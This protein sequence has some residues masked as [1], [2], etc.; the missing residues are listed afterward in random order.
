MKPD[1][2][3][4]LARYNQWANER[5][6]AACGKLHDNELF[7]QRPSFFGSIHATLNHI[8]V[9]DRIWMGR[10]TGHP[11]AVTG[12]DEILYG[13]FIGL[14]VARVAEDAQIVTFCDALDEPTVN[15]TLRYKNMAGEAQ[16]MPIRWVLTHMFNHQTHHRGQTHGLLSQTDVPPP[17]LDLVYYLRE[18]PPAA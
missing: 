2:F 14:N 4:V 17:S 3:R 9:A 13:D 15:T 16:A 1:H 18:A 7:M 12:L 6:Y 5:L 11:A 10:L 8:L